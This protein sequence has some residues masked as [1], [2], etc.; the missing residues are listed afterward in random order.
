MAR[1]GVSLTTACYPKAERGRGAAL[2]GGGLLIINAVACLFSS[3]SAEAGVP[4]AQGKV[5]LQASSKQ[6]ADRRDGEGVFSRPTHS[7]CHLLSTL[8]DTS[9]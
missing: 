8:A 3:F 7:C 6:G 5:S 4:T 1:L 2:G 9:C